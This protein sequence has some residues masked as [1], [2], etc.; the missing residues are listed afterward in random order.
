[1][2]FK[3]KPIASAVLF[4]IYISAPA[5]ISAQENSTDDSNFTGQIEEI[6][7]IG[8][9]REESVQKVPIS[10]TVFTEQAIQDAGIDQVDDFLALTPG[11][12]FSNSQDAGTN[13][14]SIRGLSQVRNGEAPV[15]VVVDGVLQANSRSFDQPLF[16]ISSVEVLR[17]PQGAL[18]GRN[19][20]GGAIIITTKAP[21]Q[22]TEGYVQAGFGDGSEFTTEGSISGGLSD[23]VT[24][25]VSARYKTFD[26][27]L[28]NFVTGE[29]VDYVDEVALRG[30]LNYQV[31]DSVSVDFRGSLVNTEGG[32]L[33][34]SYQPAVVDRVTGLPS[35]FDFGISDADLVERE[36]SANNEGVDERDASQLSM[37]VNAELSFATL[38]SVTSYDKVEQTNYA[39]QF[40]YTRATQITVAP[41]FPFFDG[42]QSGYFDVEAVSQ[43]FR[44][45]S[46]SENAFRWLA[47]VYYLKT[48][49]FVNLSIYDDLE[50][51]LPT[52]STD[53]PVFDALAPQTSFIADDNNNKATALFFNTEYDISDRLELAVA[54]RY[55]KDEREQQVASSQGAYANGV[56][57]AP[58]GVPGSVN[59]REFSLFQPKVSLRYEANDSLNVYGSWGKGFRSGQFN[60]NGVGAIAAG[61]GI[62]GVN[63]SI[64]Q[65]ETTTA[66][67]GIKKSW[68][69]GRYTLNGSI[70]STDV[71]NAPY[72]VFIGGVGAQVLVPIEDVEITGGEL[73]FS[74]NV[75]DALD[76]YASVGLA[77]SEIKSYLVNPTAI[78]NKAPYIADSTFNIGLQY[79][80]P[81]TTGMNLFARADY[82]VR[83]EQFWDPENSTARSS[84]S[85]ANIRFGL[86]DIDETWSVTASID[87][88]FDEE[89]NSEWVSGGFAHA[90]TPRLWRVQ[91]RYNY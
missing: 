50:N 81:V 39:D 46:R 24:G 30:H 51:G 6:I 15:A 1:M 85:L 72:F 68:D 32:A 89:Y 52:I 40:P 90:G 2:K 42:I 58:I 91:A 84:I 44:L 21:T 19:A 62:A 9:G 69:G 79:R 75:S 13:F 27:V 53:G 48:N 66:E 70:Y 64:D 38:S 12:T 59:K 78:G 17:G 36:F 23:K 60:Q 14:I 29:S 28:D 35:A 83:G 73:E 67:L 82:E 18:Y 86:E 74:A 4:S 20:T 57:V 49:R 26:G 34:F 63:D 5:Y 45:T 8:T 71:E 37:R 47:G 3:L 88:A 87:N 25:R 76:F 54:G 61:A 43:E 22:E 56:L 33:N 7:V 41:P 10:E 55:D 16:D 80:K 31:T 77:D 11:V 65:E